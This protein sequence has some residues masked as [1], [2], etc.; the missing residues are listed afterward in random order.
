MTTFAARDA[1]WVVIH[2]ETL[3][4]S[5]S[6]RLPSFGTLSV[7]PRIWATG[8]R[9]A[10]HDPL[11]GMRGLGWGEKVSEVGSQIFVDS[12]QGPCV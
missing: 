2:H 4:M 7:H 1:S 10:S 11:W 6:I 9:D 5:A 3:L 12:T 8:V